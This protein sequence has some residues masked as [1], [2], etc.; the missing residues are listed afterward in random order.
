MAYTTESMEAPQL[1]QALAEPSEFNLPS[2]EFVGYD[3][4]GTTTITGSQISRQSDTSVAPATP[5]ET[6][7][8][9]PKVSA[10][11]RKEQQ[12][13][14]REAT[15]KAREEQLAVK[16]ADAEKYAQLKAKIASKD[17][18]AADELGLDYNEFL[19]HELDKQPVSKEEERVR[20]LEEE[21]ASFKKSQ[22]EKVEEEYKTNQSLWKNEITKLVNDNEDF[23]TIKELGAI[24]LVLQHVNE[25]FEEDGIELTAEQAAKE[26]EEALIARAE[27]FASLSKIK[28]KTAPE[29]KVLGA[30]KSAT[31]TITNNMTTLPPK[32]T[33]KPFHMLSEAEQIAEAFRR[34]QAQRTQR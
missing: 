27:K 29:P 18:S 24:D 23:S 33:S 11:A 17:Y 30:P 22:N 13:R 28:N 8:L 31:K 12:Q 7:T 20:R 9:S 26:I 3:P 21:L 6:V 25:S 2:K 1:G 34:V 32:N 15:L 19:R 14:Q 16:I 4:K 5:E 10:L